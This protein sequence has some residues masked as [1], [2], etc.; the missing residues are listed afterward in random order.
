MGE[1]DQFLDEVEAELARLPRRTTTS[2]RSSPPPSTVRRRRRRRRARA[3]AGRPSR[4]QATRAERRAEPR[5][6]RP[7][8]LR[9]ETIKVTTVGRGLQRRGPAARARHPQRRRARRRGQGRG[10]QDRRRGPHQGRAPGGREQGQGRPARVRR[11]HPRRRSSTPRPSERRQQLFGDLE[12][13]KDSLDREVENL[14]A[15]EREYR[16]R[17]KSYFEQQLPA[18][19]GSGEGGDRSPSRRPR[20]QAAAVRCS[21]TRT[22]GTRRLSPTHATPDER[23]TSRCAA[24]DD[25]PRAGPCS[26]VPGQIR[27][28]VKASPRSSSLCDSPSPASRLARSSVASTSSAIRSRVLAQR[29]GA[30]RRRPASAARSGR[31]R[32]SRWSCGPPGPAG[33]PR[34][35]GRPGAAPG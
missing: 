17:L 27:S 30:S 4:S 20:A 8:R 2:A 3:G 26:P 35:P 25:R 15:F 12:R 24:R 10:R 23:P 18:L 5:L 7:L 6:R 13:E 16:S 29:L 9:R 34:G 21:A 19:D 14:R 31:R 1:V 11:P 33:R 22:T 32:R 28:T